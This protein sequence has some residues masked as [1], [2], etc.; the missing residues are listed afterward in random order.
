[1]SGLTR[2][3]AQ[4]DFAAG[5]TVALGTNGKLTA[6]QN[7]F[8]ISW[9][10]SMTGGATASFSKIGSGTLSIT[11]NTN[12]FTGGFHLLSGNGNSITTLSLNGTLPL[13]SA[14]T[15]G[16]WGNTAGR[17]P[18]LVLDSTTT[19]LGT[20]INDSQVITSNAG[21]L[22]FTT[23]ASSATSET[24]SCLPARE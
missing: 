4:L 23:N 7:N 8:P 2:D 1:M 13:Q 21:E 20:R 24:I 10:G 6:G 11:S 16:A 19:N 14:F 18:T 9:A 12:T 3:I 15:L 5:T 17:G 22:Q